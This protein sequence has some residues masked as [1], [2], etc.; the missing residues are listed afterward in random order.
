VLNLFLALHTASGEKGS[1]ALFLLIA[2]PSVLAIGLGGFAGG[3][4]DGAPSMVFGY[5]AVV[6]GILLKLGPQLTAKP[7]L[8]GAYWAYVFPFAALAS[9]SVQ[10]AGSRRTGAMEALAWVLV[11]GAQGALL[12]VFCRMTW[13]Q[14]QAS[15]A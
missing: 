4:F 3:N 10:M 2:P 9:L 12:A 11:V 14:V 6:L 1:P 15:L 7:T 8:F 5:C 13:H